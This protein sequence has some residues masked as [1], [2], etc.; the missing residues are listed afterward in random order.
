[1]KQQRISI[2]KIQFHERQEVGGLSSTE[3]DDFQDLHG[4]EENLN[5]GLS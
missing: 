2:Q 3:S 1:M 4:G 5:S